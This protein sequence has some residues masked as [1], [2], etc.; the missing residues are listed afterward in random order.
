MI[1]PRPDYDKL[2]RDTTP[3]E[4]AEILGALNVT[5]SE[6]NVNCSCPHLDHED[7][8]PSCSIYR[9]DGVTLLKCHSECDFVGN[10]DNPPRVIRVSCSASAG[11]VS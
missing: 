6:G 2:N 5:V 11:R 9:H 4:L 3:S 7:K 8:N 10:P 1:A